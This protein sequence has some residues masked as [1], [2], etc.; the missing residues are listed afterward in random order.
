[1]K[2]VLRLIGEAVGVAASF[3]AFVALIAKV[4][5][6]WGAQLLSGH[7]S[8]LRN[9]LVSSLRH[10]ECLDPCLDSDLFDLRHLATSCPDSSHHP[11]GSTDPGLGGIGLTHLLLCVFLAA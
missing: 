3:Y 4:L 5:G 10:T 1:M 2:L 7:P 8:G 6:V 11:R 9:P